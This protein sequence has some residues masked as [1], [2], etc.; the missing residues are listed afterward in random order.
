MIISGRHSL[1][2]CAICTYHT[3]DREGFY[4]HSTSSIHMKGI[5]KL[6]KDSGMIAFDIDTTLINVLRSGKPTGE[7]RDIEVA[8]P[9]DSDSKSACGRPGTI[10]ST[11]PY[12]L[13]SSLT[14][15]GEIF[16]SILL[17]SMLSRLSSM[18]TKRPHLRRSGERSKI[19]S[20]AE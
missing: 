14:T 18:C 20:H 3:G 6:H 16:T 8:K 13:I 2:Y 7:E 1:T 10:S 11:T 5:A 12:N 17:A 4:A 19:N 15:T 9:A